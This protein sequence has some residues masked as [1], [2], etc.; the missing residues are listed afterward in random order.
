MFV[1]IQNEIEDLKC[2]RALSPALASVVLRSDARNEKDE[3]GA[4]KRK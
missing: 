1:C 3:K 4:R 2:A